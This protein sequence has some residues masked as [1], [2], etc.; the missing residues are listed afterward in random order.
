MK[1]ITFLLVLRS[2][3]TE[4]EMEKRSTRYRF[5]SLLGRVKYS[6]AFREE[7][8]THKRVEYACVGLLSQ[9]FAHA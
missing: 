8:Y 4:S 7:K 9:M 5:Q 6:Y 1:S 2:D 3:H